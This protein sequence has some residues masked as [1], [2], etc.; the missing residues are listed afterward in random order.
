MRTASR[1]QPRSVP[2][3]SS[4]RTTTRSLPSAPAIRRRLAEV[5]A[6][7]A[8]AEIFIALGWLRAGVEKIVDPSWWTG[9]YL[10]A[11]LAEHDG[12]TLDWFRPF[13]D[14]VVEPWWWAIVTLV[15]LAQFALAAALLLGGSARV[16]AL[17]GGIGLNLVF[18]AAGAVNPSIFYILL[19]GGVLLWLVERDR[20]GRS[21][22]WLDI[23]VG[24]A[25]FL[26][27]ASLFSIRTLDPA[28]SVDDPRLIMVTLAGLTLLAR[29][30]IGARHPAAAV[31]D[32]EW[33][34]VSL[35]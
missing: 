10:S 25:G 18:I 13:V 9:D 23:A 20:S 33:E 11:F 19:Q 2:A 28:G 4:R 16:P 22:A 15:P 12:T 21:T 34:L 30:V 8:V 31:P 1:S 5:P 24:V 29:L 27:S 32:P 14:V 6:W 17:A 35:P 7:A 3:T 26:G